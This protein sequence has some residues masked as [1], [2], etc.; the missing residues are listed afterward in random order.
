M[1]PSYL[2]K[3]LI[4]IKY[5]LISDIHGNLPALKAVIQDAR[6][7][8]ADHYIFLGD[9]CI[10]LAYPNEVAD[11][12]RS[13]GSGFT[14]YG[15]EEEVLMQCASTTPDKWVKGQF[16]AGPWFYKIM[17]ESNRSY[18]GGLPKEIII[19][20]NS[21][22]PI[23]IFHKPQR[24]F[25]GMSPCFM[26]PQFF[27][28]GMDDK[29][30]N[31][32]TFK[33]YSNTIL[34]CDTELNS[35]ILKLENGVY[36]FGHTHIPLCWEREG[37]LLINPGSCGLPLDFNRDASYGILEWTGSSCKAELRRVAYDV[38]TVINYTRKSNYAKEVKVWSGIITK[39]LE[40]AREQAIPFIHF[41]EKYAADKNDMVRPFCAET[42]YSAY[43][44]WSEN[45][46]IFIHK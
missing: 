11:Y 46:A 43:E 34:D 9:Y 41:T 25:T 12:I 40:T 8:N 33:T 7:N 17:S 21:H 1:R 35:A 14:V 4:P 29:K 26:N 13:I 24:Y 44:A 6:E 2:N 23:F 36:I 42:W 16:E 19:K 37:R 30:F 39:E 18:L 45:E 38:S 10:G 28:K 15:N 5:A 3:E 22:P 27:A 31:C 20:E 32:E